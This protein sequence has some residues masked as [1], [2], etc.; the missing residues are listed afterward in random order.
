MAVLFLE[1]GGFQWFVVSYDID[2]DLGRI[3]LGTML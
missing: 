1:V 3:S 2:Y